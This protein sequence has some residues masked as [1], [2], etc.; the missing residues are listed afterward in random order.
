M[1]AFNYS[2][3]AYDAVLFDLLTAL[4][5]NWLLWDSVA[6]DE[7]AGRRWRAEYLKITYAAGA[8]RSY[9]DLVAKAAHN[10]GLSRDLAKELGARY[11]NFGPGRGS[12]RSAGPSKNAVSNGLESSALAQLWRR[13]SMEASL[14]P[15]SSR[16]ADRTWTMY[17]KPTLRWRHP[18]LRLRPSVWSSIQ[19]VES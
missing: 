12:P 13:G 2:T 14:A 4:L 19:L 11:A 1:S 9:E 7:A 16:Q 8:Y 18:A 5:D 15:R 10:V 3:R 17:T 6:G